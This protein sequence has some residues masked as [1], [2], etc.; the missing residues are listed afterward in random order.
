V[1]TVG[2][3]SEYVYTAIYKGVKLVPKWSF[4]FWKSKEMIKVP[5]EITRLHGIDLENP[6]MN[7]QEA[8]N[9][10]D[11]YLGIEKRKEEIKNNQL[12]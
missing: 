8:K 4:L 9:L 1:V 5:K 3:I 12:I 7:K 6:W 11:K 2:E 10:L